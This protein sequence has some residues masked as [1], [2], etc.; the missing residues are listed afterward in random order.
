MPIK[1]KSFDSYS[2]KWGFYSQARETG[3]DPR[4]NLITFLI[5][6]F[7]SYNWKTRSRKNSFPILNSWWNFP[8]FNQ[9]QI[10]TKKANRKV[11]LLRILIKIMNHCSNLG[12]YSRKNSRLLT[13]KLIRSK[14]Q[15]QLW[16]LVISTRRST[17]IIFR[18]P[19]HIN[20]QVLQR[21]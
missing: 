18:A 12:L 19:F 3:Y 14:T 5:F 17:E 11:I 13:L 6:L 7:R 16:M 2:L 15:S 9:F 1:E 10:L 8:S 21:L 4:S 20:N